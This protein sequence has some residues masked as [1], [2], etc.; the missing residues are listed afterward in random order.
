M[1]ITNQKYKGRSMVLGIGDSAV[2][3]SAVFTTIGG[4]QVKGYSST[5]EEIDTSDGDDGVHKK[6]IE[7]G[8]KTTTI[9]VSGL[10]SNNVS[11]ELMKAKEQAGLLWAFQLSGIED[12]DSIKGLFLITSFEVNGEHNGAQK[13]SATL[14]AQDEPIYGNV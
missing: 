3:G 11:Y 6:G 14:V 2:P 1:S 4:V 7:G 9:S 10:G 13:F 8:T 5:T 12:G